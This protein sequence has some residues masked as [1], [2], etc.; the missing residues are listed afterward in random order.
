[1]KWSIW[2]WL[3]C[4]IL[5]GLYIFNASLIEDP[6]VEHAVFAII[7]YILALY[8]LEKFK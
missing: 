5:F 7:W 4:G 2:K 3:A 6:D 8:G 1:M